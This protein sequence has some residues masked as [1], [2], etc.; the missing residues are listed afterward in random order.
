MFRLRLFMFAGLA[1]LL[2]QGCTSAGPEA[3][4][5]QTGR[6]TVARMIEAH[7]GLEKWRAA[8]TVSFTDTYIPAGE[9]SGETSR[10]T[11]EQQSRRAYL[12][13]PGSNATI[14]WD[15]EKAWGQNWKAPVPPRFLALLSYYFLNLPWLAADPG[16]NLSAPAKGKLDGDPTEYLTV[17]MTFGPGVGDT[18]DD[19]YL[20]FIDPKTYRL[21]GS[22]FTI[23]YAAVLPP[24]VKE[25]KETIVFD[26]F[27][28]VD[29]LLLPGTGTVYKEDGTRSGTFRWS[30]VS[31]RQPFDAARMQM[32]AGAV[33]DTSS[34]TWAAGTVGP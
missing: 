16:V 7:G 17:K 6:E 8:P 22:Q 23:T 24:D 26:E 4:A 15:G 34:P 25:I 18:P 29:G 1:A 12:D 31:L 3:T 14:V 5:P 20:L 10:V 19:Y 30:A 2:L 28:S 27:T 33:I 21:R 11:V 32:P 9:L 13:F